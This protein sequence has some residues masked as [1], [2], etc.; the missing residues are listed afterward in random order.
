MVKRVHGVDL[1][2]EVIHGL[3]L[4]QNVRLQTLHSHAHLARAGELQGV[5]TDPSPKPLGQLAPPATSGL[6][7]WVGEPVPG[8]CGLAGEGSW[9]TSK[10]HELGLLFLRECPG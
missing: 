4:A 6:L 1:P 3:R 8:A 9:M 5:R 2:D 10:G 7:I